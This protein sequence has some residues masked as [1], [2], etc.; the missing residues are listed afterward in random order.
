VSEV[1]HKLE[2]KLNSTAAA[3]APPV[4]TRVAA[5]ADR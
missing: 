1:R 4:S 5:H 3:A 2:A